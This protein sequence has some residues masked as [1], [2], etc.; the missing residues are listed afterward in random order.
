MRERMVDLVADELGLDPVELRRRNLVTPDDLPYRTGFN[1]LDTEKPISY[2]DGDYPATF[3]RALDAIDYER[4][5]AEI[6]ARRDDGEMIGLGTSTFIEVGNPGVFEQSRVVSEPD[7]TFTA[8]VGIASVGQGVETVLSQ[9]AA[10]RL[11]VPIERVLISYHDTAVVPEG[12]GAFSSRATVWGG[13]AICGAVDAL[14]ARAMEVAA[15]RMGTETDDLRYEAGAVIR[16]GEADVAEIPLAELGVE[17]EYRYEPHIASDI[18]MGANAAI[19][20]VDPESGGLEILRYVISYEIGRAINPLTLEGQVR[21]AAAQGIGGTLLEEFA[22]DS[23]GQPV[24]ASFMDYSMATATEIPDVEVLLLE[25]AEESPDSPLGGAKGGG[26]GG[27]IA[28]APT[29]CNAVSDALGRA[30]GALTSLPLTPERILEGVARARQ[31]S[32]GAT[33]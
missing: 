14:I 2:V 10:D 13:H 33:P 21:G 25:L 19:V 15:E 27:I 17:A 16:I 8:H 5:R 20:R 29:L 9:I 28:I 11:G 4:L 23:E 31:R 6:D 12:Q 30:G 32:A 18:M 3:D 26:E 24:S 22:Y 1:D 7:G